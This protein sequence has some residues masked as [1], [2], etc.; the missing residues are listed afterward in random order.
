MQG[1]WRVFLLGQCMQGLAPPK[2]GKGESGEV[3]L[4]DERLAEAG[5]GVFLSAI[6]IEEWVDSWFTPDELP[7]PEADMTVAE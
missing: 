6:R 2:V 7:P 4:L 1:W 3:A 5:E